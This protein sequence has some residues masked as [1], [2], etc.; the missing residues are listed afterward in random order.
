MADPN[1]FQTVSTFRGP[2]PGEIALTS[3]DGQI[4]YMTAAQFNEAMSATGGFDTSNYDSLISY[5]KNKQAGSGA[6]APTSLVAPVIAAPASIAQP[7]TVNAPAAS[8][9]PQNGSAASVDVAK[10]AAFGANG[11]PEWSHA[12]KGDG[13][14][15]SGSRKADTL[16][17][18]ERSETLVGGY[19]NDKLYAGGG[20]DVLDGGYGN[21]LLDGGIG[22][23][24]LDGGYG[25]DRLF[26]GEGN[27]YLKAGYGDDKLY[28]GAG[29]D[30]LLGGYGS[31]L[32][33]GDTGDD[34]LDGG[35]DDDKLF[36][37]AGRDVLLGGYGSDLL[38]GQDGDDSLKGGYDED[39]LRAGA[40]HDVLN[41]GAGSDVLEGGQGNDTYVFDKQSGQDI[42]RNGDA[43][44]NDQVVFSEASAARANRLWFSRKGNDLEV[45]VLDSD[46]QVG[47]FSN[48]GGFFHTSYVQ[49]TSYINGEQVVHV[50][51]D[52]GFTGNN[53]GDAAGTKYSGNP[54]K[55]TLSNWYGNAD[56]RVDLFRDAAGQTLKASQVDNLTH[57]MAAFGATP[58]SSESLNQQQWKTLETVIAANWA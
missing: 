49:T 56:A 41:G 54:D 57:A 16:R 5:V 10:T 47:I 38:E 22:D 1:R 51:G 50:T 44:G 8:I 3:S 25:D 48:S 7:T 55:I 30:V 53:G 32:L 15:L 2:K 37:G 28:G 4:V 35:Y 42:I 43:A 33:E 17:G 19:G 52:N 21:D 36:G 6:V 14:R 40:G 26:G 24:R 45:T 27:D 20:N 11:N 9:V 12:Y 46:K 58:A 29:R 18:T 13:G 23:D 39:T 34:R 31:D